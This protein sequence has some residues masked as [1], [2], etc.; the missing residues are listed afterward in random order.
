MR[1]QNYVDDDEKITRVT[2]T[3]Q[4]WIEIEKLGYLVSVRFS[5]EGEEIVPVFDF[6]TKHV[7]IE[8]ET[9]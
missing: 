1:Q 4:T 7:V 3:K 9:N 8:I 6:F 5:T 2:F